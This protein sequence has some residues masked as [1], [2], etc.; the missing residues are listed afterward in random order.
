MKILHLQDWDVHLNASHELNL[1]AKLPLD[2]QLVG[3]MSAP[4]RSR[5]ILQRGGGGVCVCDKFRL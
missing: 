5:L 4:G 3:S 2:L 1:Q